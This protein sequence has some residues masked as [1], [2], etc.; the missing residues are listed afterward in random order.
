MGNSKV[1]F[2]T[3]YV[4]PSAKTKI[5]SSLDFL[6]DPS[7]FPGFLQSLIS[8]FQH[9]YI[10]SGAPFIF[11]SIKPPILPSTDPLTAPIILLSKASIY[12]LS[13]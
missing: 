10:S 3:P 5:P 13:D 9:K 7:I 12:F 6:L 1:P 8:S 11:P 4:S 2:D